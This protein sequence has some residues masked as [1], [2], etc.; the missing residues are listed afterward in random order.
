MLH[1]EHAEWDGDGDSEGHGND[2]ESQVVQRG[3]ENFGAMVEEE[4]PGTHG[5]TPLDTARDAVK[6]WTSG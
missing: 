6:A 4:V 2:D 1:D 5:E 3:A